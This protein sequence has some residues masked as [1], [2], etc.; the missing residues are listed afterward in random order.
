MEKKKLAEMT[1]SEINDKFTM[2]QAECVNCICYGGGG[3]ILDYM[4]LVR[5][6][7]LKQA[8]KNLGFE[9]TEK[10][11]V[12]EIFMHL[13]EKVDIKEEQEETEDYEPPFDED[14]NQITRLL[15]EMGDDI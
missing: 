14:D 9:I 15:N 5:N 3:C 10:T 2:C 6:D 1:I 7:S 4:P 11:T 13:L 12:K 8:S